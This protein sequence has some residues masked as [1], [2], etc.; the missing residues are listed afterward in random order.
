MK[1]KENC[2]FRKNC[3]KY[4]GCKKTRILCE[5]IHIRAGRNMDLIYM[6]IFNKLCLS[7]E[8][9][10]SKDSSV[11]IMKFY[12]KPNT[13]WIDLAT[14][15]LAKT[16]NTLHNEARFSWRKLKVRKQ[17]RK[18]SNLKLPSD[19]FFNLGTGRL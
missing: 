15:K 14:K 4:T 7:I 3:E 8:N 13:A 19:I 10:G 16:S 18:N 12:S 1:K 2:Y 9:I 5:D 17:I 11:S 6:L